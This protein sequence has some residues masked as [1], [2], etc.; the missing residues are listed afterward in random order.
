MKARLYA[1]KGKLY[2]SYESE[3]KKSRWTPRNRGRRVEFSVVPHAGM[4]KK[5]NRETRRLLVKAE[6]LDRENDA[7]KEILGSD[8]TVL[9][10]VN[11]QH[12]P[13]RSFGFASN[14]NNKDTS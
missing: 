14:N 6:Q 3:N 10:L 4:S 7:E 2:I 8:G 9:R 13:R 12:L 1:P 5:L 11:V